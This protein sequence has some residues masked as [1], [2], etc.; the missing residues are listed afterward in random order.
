MFSAIESWILMILH[1]RQV[2]SRNSH[3]LQ[4]WSSLTSCVIPTVIYALAYFR[5][6]NMFPTNQFMRNIAWFWQDERGV[7]WE[8]KYRAAY[9][10][11]AHKTADEPP[12]AVSGPVTSMLARM[13]SQI[14]RR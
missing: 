10:A 7:V 12:L 3:R 1:G 2:H 8:Q 5:M 14:S 11:A 4:F 6:L 13:S 9:D